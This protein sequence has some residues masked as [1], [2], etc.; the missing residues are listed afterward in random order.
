M[1]EECDSST[2]QKIIELLQSMD[3]RESDDNEASSS[4]N[5]TNNNTTNNITNNNTNN[6][7]INNSTNVSIIINNFGQEKIDH[8]LSDY[9]FMKKC[10]KNLLSHGIVELL[11]KIHFDDK[12]PENQNIKFKSLKQDFIEIF[13]ENKWNIVPGTQTTET[14]TRKGCILLSEFYDEMMKEEM[15]D[16]DM[17]ERYRSKMRTISS[18]TGNEY[19]AVRKNTKTMLYDE[20]QKQKNNQ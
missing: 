11:R 18:K 7:N 9:N 16:E 12:H 1:L 14:M 4:T 15:D 3:H 2:R 10:F 8:I 13:K 19:Y 6:T 17:D 5:I 20:S